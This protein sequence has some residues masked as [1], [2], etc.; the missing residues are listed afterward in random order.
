MMLTSERIAEC[1]T[2]Y[3]WEGVPWDVVWCEED[4]A[5]WRNGTFD[6]AGPPHGLEWHMANP[7]PPIAFFGGR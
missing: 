6:P 3:L 2:A 5:A 1:L 7:C 4:L